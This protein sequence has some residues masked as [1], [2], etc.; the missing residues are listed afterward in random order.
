[1]TRTRAFERL[2]IVDEVG[3]E[4][5]LL[6]LHHQIRS[7]HP[8]DLPRSPALEGP[9]P[10]RTLLGRPEAVSHAPAEDEE[11]LLDQIS[12]RVAYGDPSG[13]PRRFLEPVALRL[14][15][16]NAS[17]AIDDASEVGGLD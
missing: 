17:L 12:A 15:N 10:A 4:I 14:S 1:V 5:R 8:D 6:L 7:N 13:V 9:Q 11:E 3:Q 16:R 2:K